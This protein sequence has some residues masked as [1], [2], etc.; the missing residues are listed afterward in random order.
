MRTSKD[1]KH[2]QGWGM[3]SAQAHRDLGTKTVSKT[4]ASVSTFVKKLVHPHQ[5]SISDETSSSSE[6]DA[7]SFTSTNSSTAASTTASFTT[8]VRATL[9][10]PPEARPLRR[11]PTLS[12]RLPSLPRKVHGPADRE[13]FMEMKPLNAGSRYSPSSV[14]GWRKVWVELR[15][16]WLYLYRDTFPDRAL[17]NALCLTTGYQVVPEDDAR[18]GHSIPSSSSRPYSFCLV[19]VAAESVVFS[20]P[21]QLEMVTWVKHMVLATQGAQRPGPMPI[22]PLKALWN[23]SAAAHMQSSKG[24]ER[25]THSE[26]T[27]VVL[28]PTQLRVEVA[29]LISDLGVRIV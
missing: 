16:D 6:N 18:S 20:A 29:D 8:V 23:S 11:K 12:E 2:S 5:R 21:S 9:K 1:G 22:I 15:E 24:R 25:P 14:F 19:H 10:D 27:T 7:R 28:P 26:A 17:F 4:L 3:S 13:G